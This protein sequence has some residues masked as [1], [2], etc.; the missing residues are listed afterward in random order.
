M[1]LMM[2]QLR[3]DKEKFIIK[4]Y[5]QGKS[6]RV[7]CKEGR[8]SFRG[9]GRMIRKYHGEKESKVVSNQSKAYSMFLAG[10][11][12]ISVAIHPGLGCEV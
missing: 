5:K 11:P 6:S 9:F 7:I 10:K 4:P 8:I 12:S 1:D 2:G 3:K